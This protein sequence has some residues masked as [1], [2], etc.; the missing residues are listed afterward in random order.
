MKVYYH[1]R[2][3]YIIF[4]R[5]SIYAIAR[6]YHANSVR[7]SVCQTCVLYQNG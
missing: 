5:D 1:C 7:L 4:T 6:I 3:F 2:M